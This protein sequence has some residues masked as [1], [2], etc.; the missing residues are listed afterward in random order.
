[1]KGLAETK[2]LTLKETLLGHQIIVFGNVAVAVA[3]CELTE[4]DTEVNRAV[5]ITLLVKSR[6]PWQIVAQAWD[7]ESPS[8]PLPPGL[9]DRR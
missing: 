5:E 4:N 3:G 9:R 2:L 1:M 6:E 8:E 7:T